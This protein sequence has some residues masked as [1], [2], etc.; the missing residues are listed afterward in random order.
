MLKIKLVLGTIFSI[1]LKLWLVDSTPP[2]NCF[3]NLAFFLYLANPINHTGLFYMFLKLLNQENVSL[4]W[5][6]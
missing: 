2:P 1:K 5:W 4:F 3:L 6:E